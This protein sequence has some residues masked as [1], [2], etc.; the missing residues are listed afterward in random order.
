[1]IR[2]VILKSRVSIAA[3]LLIVCRTALAESHHVWEKVEIVLRADKPYENPYTD[4]EVWV[5]LQGPGFDKRC[6][7]FW[8][9]G[10]AFRVRVLA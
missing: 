10:R 2:R 3:L 4:V 6:Y 1:M 7:G 5:D 8:D 9:G